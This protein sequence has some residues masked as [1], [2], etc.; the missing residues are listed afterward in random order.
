MEIL[1]V[2]ALKAELRERVIPPLIRAAMAEGRLGIATRSLAT[3]GGAQPT[4]AI[5]VAPGRR[6]G[7]YRLALRVQRMALGGEALSSAIGRIG[8]MVRG[9]HDIRMIGR[10]RKRA[11]PWHQRR[12][13]PLMIGAS[14]GHVAITAGTLGAVALH[15][16]SGAPVLLSNSHVLADEGRAEIGDPV[17]Q[18][19]ALDRGRRPVDV[20]GRLLAAHPLRRDR[21]NLVDAAI[22][23]IADGLFFDP[24]TLRGLGDLVGARQDPVDPEEEVS[25]LGRTTGLTH[26]RVTAVELDHVVV[27]FE[28]GDLA[29]DNQIEIESTG[30]GPFSAGGDSGSL[31]VDRGM[32]AVGLLFAGSDQGGRNGAGL[33]YANDIGRVLRALKLEL[34]PGDFFR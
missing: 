30:D 11:R 25:K 1:S 13:R 9:E 24:E 17:L 34:K 3:A 10:V 14:I 20:V 2:R 4:I 5:G 27:G 22:A 7:D 15:R 32:R 28:I 21:A 6:P 26:G 12:Q 23:G 18:P 16:P 19:G 33:T 29:F 8:E 31:I